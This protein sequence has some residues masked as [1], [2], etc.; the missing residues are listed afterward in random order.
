MKGAKGF[1][2]I[3]LMIVVVVLG[4]LAAM[5]IAN[6]GDMRIRANEASTKSNMHTFQLASEDYATRNDGACADLA[7]S[8]AAVLAGLP[9]GAT[10]KNPFDKSTGSE[11]SWRDQSTWA[12][13]MASG[14]TKAG[15]V[16]Y[17]DSVNSKYQIV[18][19]GGKNGD[20]ALI[21]RSGGS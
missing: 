10:F 16:A 4:I 13:T 3:E 14:T 9:A 17:G 5:A 12:A 21:L 15:C 1:T 11:N 20:L 6:Y 7:S 19:R 8:V 18:G 2:L